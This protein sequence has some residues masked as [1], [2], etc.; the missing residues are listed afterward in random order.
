ME[1]DASTSTPTPAEAAAEAP[2]VQMSV[3]EKFLVKRELVGR[4][5]G[6]QQALSPSKS[7]SR[8]LV[9]AASPSQAP[10]TLPLWHSYS[11]RRHGERVSRLRA[12]MRIP[13]PDYTECL[14]AYV[15][16]KKA[17]RLLDLHADAADVLA[18]Y[19]AATRAMFFERAVVDRPVCDREQNRRQYE[20]EMRELIMDGLALS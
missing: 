17:Q 12:A 9:T 14:D 10:P 8:R 18:E 15:R 16:R 3:L 4:V 7:A 20:E 5:P 13:E 6:K 1:S 19:D 2:T 11:K